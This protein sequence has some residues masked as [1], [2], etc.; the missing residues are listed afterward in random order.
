MREYKCDIL[1]IGAGLAGSILGFLLRM[2]GKDVLMVELLD[3]KEKD[4]LCGG[5]M[6]GGLFGQY[7][8]TF[9]KGISDAVFPIRMDSMLERCCGY[10]IESK[11]TII[12]LSRKRLDDY[13]LHRYLELEGRLL[14]RM[15]T[16]EIDDEKGIAVCE[17]MRNG[18]LI[19]VRYD[20]LVGADGASSVTRRLTTGR[21]QR[22]NVT[23][24][25][26]VP[27]LGKEI[28]FDYHIPSNGYS[29]YIP[30]EKD[31]VAGCGAL[32]TDYDNEIISIRDKLGEFCRG[33]GIEAPKKLRGAPLPT[34]DD[35]LLMTGKRTFFVGDAAGL[36]NS[37]TG[38]GIQHA[39]WS[40][41]KLAGALCDGG[42][43]EEAM[44]PI[45]ECVAQMYGRVNT[46]YFLKMYEI[47][48]KGKPVADLGKRVADEPRGRGLEVKINP[49]INRTL[50]R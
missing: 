11:G 21:A 47:R 30:W 4:K 26:T 31:A 28:V 37:C 20:R 49:L 24:E 7:E 39:L 22:V 3:A 32:F 38:G 48:K 40:A 9:G 41:Q 29:W 16:R 42:S 14:D 6:S 33:L 10:E 46:L 18:E 17:D 8:D 5:L 44:R 27:I 1:I 13:V 50:E 2:S 34:G 25:G 45:V 15:A 35:V 12:S 43:Y 36:I 19:R 23:F